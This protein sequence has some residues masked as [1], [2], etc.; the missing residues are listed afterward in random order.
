MDSKVFYAA[1]EMTPFL[2]C[3]SPLRACELRLALGF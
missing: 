3:R 2:F 1:R